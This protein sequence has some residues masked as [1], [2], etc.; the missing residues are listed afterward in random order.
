MR[1]AHE[2]TTADVDAAIDFVVFNGAEDRGQTVSYS[3]T[4][5]AAGLVSPQNLHMS[6]ESQIV[7][8]FMEQFHYRCAERGLPPLDALVV[9]VAGQRE[10]FPGA[11]YFRV[12]GHDDPLS[13]KT[14][15]DAAAAATDFWQAQKQTCRDWGVQSR[16]GHA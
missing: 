16:R 15:P 14:S 7:T 8:Q 6:G 13:T 2:F 10:S 11:G 5:D 12:N 9:H 4:F 3:R 1:V